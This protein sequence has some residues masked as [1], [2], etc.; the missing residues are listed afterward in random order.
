MIKIRNIMEWGVIAVTGG[1]TIT[2]V[3]ILVFILG[4]IAVKGMPSI[5]LY[6]LTTAESNTPGFGQGIANAII[7][8]IIISILSVLIA[9][10]AAI[11]TALYLKKYASNNIITRTVGFLLDVLSGT[12]SIVLGVFGL[13][14]L[15]Y[16]LGPW[17]G[18]YSL[19]SG[20]I[21]LSILIMPVI[22]RATEDAL[23]TV[24]QSLEDGSYALGASKW[25]TI[26]KI[27]IPFSLSGII[28]GII[29]ATGR[30]A[31]ES[32]IVMLTAGYTQFMPSIGTAHTDK[33]WYGIKIY[34]LND[35]IGTLPIAI[36]H[37]YEFPTMVPASNGFAAAIVLILI[38]MFIN[39]IA[40]LILWKW[41]IG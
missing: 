3:A 23:V 8:T 25:E 41:K 28:T 15:V 24:P 30:A 4:T 21:A 22:E 26:K 10:P 7:G 36:Y 13:F 34:P 27:A 9:I 18:G 6:F 38:V 12:P 16:Y 5:N 29:L 37:A 20:A 17:T 39:A 2:T 31:E 19:I 32:A 40:R 33:I 14:M 1:A 35:L 11:G